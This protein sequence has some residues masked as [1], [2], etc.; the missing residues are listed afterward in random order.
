MDIHCPVCGEPWDND[1][2]HEIAGERFRTE[3]GYSYDHT[4]DGD[5]ERYR[6]FYNQAAADFRQEGCKLF[7]TSHNE[8]ECDG[9][10]AGP[11]DPMGQTVYCDGSCKVQRDKVFG[12][13][14]AEASTA[15]YDLLGDDMDGAAA[16]MEDMGF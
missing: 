5:P 7:G 3:Y 15:L 8:P 16:M 12:L 6:A 9:H 14:A 4:R 10:P 13:T 1:E 11:H 2:V